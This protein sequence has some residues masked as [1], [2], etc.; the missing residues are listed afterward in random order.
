LGQLDTIRDRKGTFMKRHFIHISAHLLFLLIASAPTNAQI[1]AFPGAEGFGAYAVGGRGGDVYHVTTLEDDDPGSLRYGIENADGPRTIVFDISGNIELL[2]YLYVRS[3]YMTIAG[4]TA[5]GQGICIQNYGLTVKADH[6]ILRHLRFRPGDSYIG[7]HDDGGFTEDALTLGGTNIIADHISTS[8]GIDENLSCSTSYDS[9]TI[10][11]CIIAEGLHQTFYFHGEHDPT[12][13]G[14]SMGSLIKPR[15]INAGASLH[16]NLWAHNNNRNPAVG[17]YE[18]TEHVKND[19]R[20]NVMYNCGSFGYSSGASAKADLNYV[21]NYIIAGKSTSSSKRSQAFDANEPNNM[22]I[23]QSG[24]KIDSDLDA[25]RD[26]K[27]TGW[28]MFADTWISHTEEFPMPSIETVSAELAYEQVLNQAGAFYWQRDTVDARIINDV[29][30]GTGSIIDS[31]NQVGGYP[32]IPVVS[33]PANW[34]TDQDGMPDWW[35]DE[36]SLDH[37]NPADRNDDPDSNGYTYL[38]EYLNRPD[39]LTH[40]SSRDNPSTF[41][42]K[43]RNYPNPLNPKT[44]I[45]FVLNKATRVKVLVFDLQGKTI[46]ELLHEKRDAGKQAIN[47]NANNLPSGLYLYKVE[48]D[49]FFDIGKMLLIR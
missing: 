44:S 3:S 4:Q 6:V 17:S 29:R 5:P 33:R 40:I 25:V 2:S 20:N 34:D 39:F 28:S 9:V 42:L 1:K 47:F 18:G 46:S 7:P 49:D 36:N 41:D 15:E 30:N 48:T 10:Q 8:W 38:E 24:N 43:L 37:E 31:Q 32:I 21:G 27:D 22:H 19:V 16:H 23:Y 45:E 13:S 12:H 26:G 11:H 35:E 14:H